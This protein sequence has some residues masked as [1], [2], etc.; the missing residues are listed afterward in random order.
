VIV[1][2]WDPAQGEVPSPGTI[3]ETVECSQKGTYHDCPPEHPT[4]R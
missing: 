2:N 4:S 1:P 3:I